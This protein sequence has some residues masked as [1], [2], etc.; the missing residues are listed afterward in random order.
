MTGP[1]AVRTYPAVTEAEARGA[2]AAL[3][4]EI[5][6]ALGVPVVNL[7][8]RHLATLPG[9]LEWAWATVAPFYRSGA[10]ARAGGALLRALP[11]PAAPGWSRADLRGAGVDEAAERTVL[12][13]LDSYNR[14]NAMNLVALTALTRRLQDG[15]APARTAAP[16]GAP[17]D[18]GLAGDGALPPLLTPAQL[19]PAT[20]E[21]VARLDRLGEA[22]AE[23]IPASMYRHLAHWPGFLALAAARIAPLQDD[24]RLA[25]LI[26]AGRALAER[27]AAG[28]AG[29]LAAPGPPPPAPADAAVPAALTG[30]T[31]GVIA[32]MVPICALLRRA[33]PE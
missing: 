28:A 5:R 22:A 24:G 27:A 15:G 13:V 19:A 16:A 10:A 9:G 25:A 4:A 3:F 30:F 2:T 11:L 1:G 7:V 14:S 12:R 6:Q 29:E 26:T 20:A 18:G 21:L 23:R 31:R 33:M 17:G 8:W 32:K